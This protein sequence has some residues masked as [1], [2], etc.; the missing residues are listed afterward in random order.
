V[1]TANRERFAA[2]VRSGQVDLG[3]ACLLIGTEEDPELVPAQWLAELDRLADIAG[4]SMR[5]RPTDPAGLAAGLATALG[6]HAGFGG[7]VWD[8]ADLRSSLLHEV[9]RR[10]R[11]LPILLSVVWLEVAQRL[12]IPAYGVGLP[13]RFVVGIGA[14]DGDHV[15]VDPFRGG[16]RLTY[17]RLC[18]L[19][20][21]H[22]PADAVDGPAVDPG[23]LR[24]AEPVAILLRILAN[25]RLWAAEPQRVRT[26]LWAVELSL[27][28][29]HHPAE[30][31]RERGLLLH[32]IG[33]FAAAADDL[34]AYAHAVRSTDEELAAKLDIQAR[35]TRARLN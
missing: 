19:V 8:Y 3:L 13:G 4:T 32:R 33:E 18:E 31:R 20:A 11:G 21:A 9:L 29:P 34:E 2:V 7:S 6:E 16:R 28:L 27:L 15:L 26:R 14:A 30:L 35:L 22:R 24:P 25:I 17:Q 1:N 12:G 10:K 23:A 5:V